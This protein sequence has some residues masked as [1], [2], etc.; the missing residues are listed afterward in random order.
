MKID[1][2]VFSVQ[3]SYKFPLLQ[4]WGPPTPPQDDNDIYIDYSLLFL[5][6]PTQM[7]ELELPPVYVKKE[8]KRSRIDAGF[9][10]DNRR[11]LKMRK[12]DNYNPPRSLFDKPSPA[13]AKLRKD[14]KL[15]RYRGIFKTPL[16][17]PALKQQMPL[18]PLVE[19][20]GMVDWIIHEDIELLN[21]VQQLQ[22]LPLN[23]M[24]LSPGHTPNWDLVSDIINQTSR[25]YRTPKHCRYRYE[26]V[27]VPREEGKLIESP[28]KQK[29]TK[30]PLK[31]TAKNLR[32]SQLYANDKNSSFSKLLK[33]K[34]DNIKTAYLKKTP[35]IEQRLVNPTLRNP[36]HAMIL[37]DF[38]VINYEG[39]LTPQ[40]IAARRVEKIKEKQRSAMPNLVPDLAQQQPVQT[41]P[42]SQI[43]ATQSPAAII[44]Q[45]QASTQQPQ[46]QPQ[47]QSI[48]SNVQSVTTLVQPQQIQSQRSTINMPHQQSPQIVKAI[49]ASPQQPSLIASTVQHIPISQAQQIQHV[50]A[51]Q[52][53]QQQQ[54]SQQNIVSQSPVSVVLTT[55]ISVMTTVPQQIQPQIVSI[56]Q[57]VI[58][59]STAIISQSTGTIVQSVTPQQQ[60]GQ[61]VSVS[62]LA[63]TVFTTSCLPTN[64]TVATLSTSS[65]RGQRIVTAPG[66]Q[67][68]VLHQRS[69]AQSPTVVSVSGI[70]GQAFTQAQ[71]QASQLRLAVSG[72]QQVT[73]VVT[74]GIPVNSVTGKPINQA[75]QSIFFRPQLR[76]QQLKVIHP[77]Q[78]GQNIVGPA[79]TII[80]G[81]IVQTASGQT[82]QLQ[83]QVGQ[84]VSV[85]TAGTP[86]QMA[87]GQTKTQFVK[88]IGGKQTITRQATEAEMLIV[89]RQLIAQPQQQQQKTQLINQ[90]Q[91]FTP[92]S[93]QIQQA[94]TSGQQQIATLVKT[95]VGGAGTV[96]MTLSQIKP[97]QLKATIPGQGSMRQIQIQQPVTL[98]QHRKTGKMTQITQVTA[99]PGTSAGI[100]TQLI[101]QNPNKLANTVTVQQIQQVIRQPTGQIVLGKASV[102]RVI[103]VT[104]S[105]QARQIQVSF[106]SCFG[107]QKHKRPKWKILFSFFVIQKLGCLVISSWWKYHSS[108]SDADE[109][110]HNAYNQSGTGHNTTTNTSDFFCFA[111]GT[112]T[113]CQSRSLAANRIRFFGC[114]HSSTAARRR[115]YCCFDA[116]YGDR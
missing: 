115:K 64:A 23:L 45:Q 7:T 108:T 8:F 87:T 60:T 28:K 20:E 12:E 80:S 16:Q 93:L 75:T 57:S 1:P 14:L 68:V 72:G 22:G 54:Q 50:Q 110:G 26:A 100:P 48:P 88:Q 67:E 25:A 65:L 59:S 70:T 114:A 3:F 77:G 30:N 39:P 102:G 36:K 78:A 38:G 95:S 85:A 52:Q 41:T 116:K 71:L 27:I 33:V 11:P 10:I 66:L 29:K 86:V 9:F 15:Q 34:Y 73:G 18:K 98:G 24:L 90:S 31:A 56:Q 79:G 37:N 104:M 49:V 51:I 46:Q 84:K 91:I 44:V 19:P 76:Q 63:G 58:P 53:Q 5:Y 83:Q 62:Q 107:S 111:S 69:N 103:P 96:G 113:K 105:S 4:L 47:L 32:T 43:I 74:K 106:S 17:I 6:E 97:G 40:E 81:G 35:P 101:V 61:V 94:G 92:S 82:V 89:K 109:H 112:T 99:K 2:F 13:L 21:V 42:P 55:P